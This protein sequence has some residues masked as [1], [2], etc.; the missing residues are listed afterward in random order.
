MRS[1]LA[2]ALLSAL[3]LTGCASSRPLQVADYVTRD[4]LYLSNVKYDSV[5]IN[6]VSYTD[7]THDTLLIRE[8]NTEY[9]YKLLRDTVFKVQH[10][11]IPY[12]VRVVKPKSNTTS[13][14]M[15]NSSAG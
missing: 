15:R 7:C 4:T 11:S 2:I 12:E 13:P 3:V 14:G 5:Y 9:R 10:D 8:T 6:N 1:S